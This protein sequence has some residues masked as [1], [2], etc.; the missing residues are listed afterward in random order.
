MFLAE[1][2]G[3]LLVLMVV[4]SGVFTTVVWSTV[5]TARSLLSVW[6]T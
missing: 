4:R 6:P 3:R 5:F 2:A 1:L